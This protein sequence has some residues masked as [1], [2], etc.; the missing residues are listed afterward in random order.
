MSLRVLCHYKVR[1]DLAL[2]GWLLFR[3]Y[4]LAVFC[5]VVFEAIGVIL[6]S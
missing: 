4:G 6:F 3:A 5:I 1:C 2:I